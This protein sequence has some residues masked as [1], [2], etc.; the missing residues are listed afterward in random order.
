M[1]KTRLVRAAADPSA[2]GFRLAPERVHDEDG[3]TRMGF[4]RA[5][6]GNAGATCRG[7]AGTFEPD[8]D[9][10]V[11]MASGEEHVPEICRG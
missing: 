7:G 8:A 9:G 10:V 6:S 3:R 5:M 11:R 4:D 2:T 1:E